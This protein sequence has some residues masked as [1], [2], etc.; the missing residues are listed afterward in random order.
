MAGSECH[1]L[2]A[3]DILDADTGRLF[4][5]HIDD[6]RMV[7]ALRLP[8]GMTFPARP[9][10][11]VLALQ[12]L[13]KCRRQAMFSSSFFTGKIYAWLTFPDSIARSRW[14][15]S[16]YAPIYHETLP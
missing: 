6:V 4:M 5:R 12:S 2:T 9:V 14:A 13:C 1:R 8:A 10:L 11:C 3:A 15:I 16:C 7:A